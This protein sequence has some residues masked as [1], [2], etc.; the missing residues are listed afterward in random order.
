MEEFNPD[1]ENKTE[2]KQ[3]KT[4]SEVSKS[5]LQYEGRS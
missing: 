4:Y 5:L 2:L 1:P 3:I